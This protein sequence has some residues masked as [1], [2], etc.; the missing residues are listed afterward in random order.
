M[1]KLPLILMTFGT[2]STQYSFALNLSESPIEQVTLYPSMAK[3]ERSI[4]VQAGEQLVSL[5]GLAANFDINQLQ[6]QTSNI[7]V[8]AVS[9]TDSALDKPAGYESSQLKKQIELT[10]FKILEQNSI[11][12]A[13]ELQN[14]FLGNV[15]EGSADKV[16]KQAYDAFVAIDQAKIEKAKLEQ[17]LSELQQDLNNIGDHQF[18]QR[19]L[20]FY[21]NAPQ[22][23]EIKLSYMVPYARWQP[24]YKA[25]LNSQTK[26]VKL[27]R[28]AMIAQKT[29][30]DW[31]NVKLTLSTSTPKSYTQQMTPTA[32][33]VDY[34]QPEA[35]NNY[36]SA[37]VVEVAPAPIARMNNKE[38]DERNNTPQ[39]PQFEGTDLNFSTEFRSETKASIH[40][41]SQ[42][43]FLP[44]SADQ[45]TAKISVWVIPRQS[46]Q[47][48]LNA[49]IP[50]LDNNWPSG[51]VKLYRDGDYVGQR[52]WSN[53]NA[54][55][56]QMNFGQNEQ[57]QVNIT[58]LNDVQ[59]PA[60]S[61]SQTQQKQRYDIQ[62]L[63]NYPVNLTV[64]EAAPQS[65][66]SKLT[67]QTRYSIEPSATSW[68]GQPN[69]NQWNIQLQPKQK[70]E[71]NIQHDFKYPSKGSTSGF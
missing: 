5:N 41:S 1:K 15:K 23:G 31:N 32:W 37:P 16:R 4:P 69:I 25:E 20:K 13:A 68:N 27:T 70:F 24:M 35:S 45:Y 61:Q 46:Q 11:I 10:Q 60:R 52:N 17:R 30:E 38:I 8:N 19:S 22:K 2:L 18:D 34:Y 47:A 40:S 48:I 7:E 21:V 71:L 58:D 29:G 51:I 43:I 53:N 14:K 62:N 12:Q 6:Y 3:I 54:D 56:V 33:W 50:K 59:N 67:A 55:T 57:I 28:M 64:F 26:Q 42:Q 44:L 65:R 49:E 39:F 63:H 9:H 36:G 66:N